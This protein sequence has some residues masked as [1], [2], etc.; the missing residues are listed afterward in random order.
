MTKFFQHLKKYIFA[1]VLAGVP[2]FLVYLVMRFMYVFIDKNVM[3]FLD[4]FIGFRLPGLGLFITIFLLYLVGLLSRNLFGKWLFNFFEGV[5]KKIPLI[6]TTYQVGKQISSTLS[7]PEKKVF[8]KVVLVNFLKDN[9][10][11]IGF[12]TGSLIDHKTGTKLFKVFVPTPPNPTTGTMIIIPES[13]IIDPGWSIDQGIRT[14]IS[15]G[16]I[17]PEEI[18]YFKS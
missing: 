16:I 5:T 18:N 10:Y 14:V 15:A 12:I 3:D 13:E 8:K 1:G 6:G 4:D 2:L 17:G 9:I 11:T 7:L